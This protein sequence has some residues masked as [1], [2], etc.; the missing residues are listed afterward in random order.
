MTETEERREIFRGHFSECLEHFIN[1]FDTR[2]PPM[3]KG[4]GNA[5]KP[6]AVFCGLTEHTVSRLIL[7]ATPAP[8][9]Q[10]RIRLISYL[11]LVGYKVIEFERLH[12]VVRN[13]M[14]LI[15]YGLLTGEEAAQILGYNQPSEIYGIYFHNRGWGKDKEEKMW[16][17]WKS[18][19]DELEGARKKA[20]S[21]PKLL[22]WKILSSRFWQCQNLTHQ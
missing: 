6:I 9:G 7:R 22:R 15:G 2:F 11:D 12:R 18:R 16:E 4:R 21:D 8:K 13:F 19:K 20:L 3:K 17:T 10:G 5:I 14:E 1:V